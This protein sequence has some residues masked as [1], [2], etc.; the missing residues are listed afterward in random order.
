MKYLYLYYTERVFNNS[1]SKK[2]KKQPHF[3]TSLTNSAG[4][5]YEKGLLFAWLIFQFQKVDCNKTRA[6]DDSF[7]SFF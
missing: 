6:S 5:L 7:C 1:L 2:K 3:N 4:A